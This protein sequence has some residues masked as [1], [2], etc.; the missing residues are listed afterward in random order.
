VERWILDLTERLAGAGISTRT[1]NQVHRATAKAFAEASRL[2]IIIRNPFSGSS[3]VK[4]TTLERK[5][6][7]N[8][9]LAKVLDPM[10]WSDSVV[11]WRVTILA[12][13]TGFRLGEILSLTPEYIKSDQIRL[14]S[15]WDSTF[16]KLKPPK[17][18]RSARDI[19][20][21]PRMAA[22]LISWAK[23]N[24]WLDRPGAIPFIFPARL[25]INR[26][27]TLT[28]IEKAFSLAMIHVGISR[29]DQK[30][31]GLSFHSIRHFVTSQPHSADLSEGKVLRLLGHA[32]RNI[33][34]RYT[35]ITIVL[36]PNWLT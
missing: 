4:E 5:L 17:T 21:T 32:E 25:V 28:A 15:A 7:T 18:D 29:E 14:R 3:K 26:P 35:H 6:F 2:E 12:F 1:V 13:S 10:S 11:P 9:E 20:I 31:R 24:P 34:D 16:N 36:L 23:E 30:Q 33:H 8:E 19:P 22:A 27:I